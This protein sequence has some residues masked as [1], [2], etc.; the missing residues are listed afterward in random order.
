MVKAFKKHVVF[1]MDLGN[2]I[3]IEVVQIPNIFLTLKC[4][5][6]YAVNYLQFIVEENE[7]FPNRKHV[8]IPT[9]WIFKPTTKAA[10]GTITVSSFATAGPH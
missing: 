10:R 4:F 6:K 2:L 8:I 3:I 1:E 9:T 7:H 5:K